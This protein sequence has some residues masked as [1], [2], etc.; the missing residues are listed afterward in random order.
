MKMRNKLLYITIS[1][2][3]LLA[4][5]GASI[6]F[7]N[8]VIKA[9]AATISGGKLFVQIRDIN[10]LKIGDNVI[11]GDGYNFLDCQAGNPIFSRVSP[12]DGGNY[13]ETKLYIPSNT[14]IVPMKVEAGGYENTY[15]FK[16]VKEA[17]LETGLSYP[18][19]DK[20]LSYGSSYTYSSGT[21][22]TLGDINFVSS[23]NDYSSWKVSFDNFGYAHMQFNSEQYSTEIRCNTNSYTRPHIGYYSPDNYYGVKLYREIDLSNLKVERAVD[24]DQTTVLEGSYIDLSGLELRIS[25]LEGSDNRTFISE[26]NTDQPFYDISAAV[27]GHGYVECSFCGFT[28]NVACNVVSQ[29]AAPTYYQEMK[30]VRNDYRGTYILGVEGS[31]LC[32]LGAITG[33]QKDQADGQYT[34]YET[35]KQFNINVSSTLDTSD[36]YD[37]TTIE[38][39]Y[40]TIQRKT[41]DGVSYLFLVSKEGEYLTN[42]NNGKDL[43]YL[44][45][46]LNVNDAI[47]IDDDLYIVRNNKKLVYNDDSELFEFVSS[48]ESNHSRIKLFK[49]I[50]DYESEVASFVSGFDS[51]THS[52]CDEN[53]INPTTID[54]EGWSSQANAFN[55][56]SP[57]AQGYLANVEYIH[58][59]EASGSTAD[60]I[61]RY[62]YIVSKYDNLSDFMNRKDANTI[63]DYTNKV[64]NLNAYPLIEKNVNPIIV[65]V[66]I[67]LI[68]LSTL[69]TFVLFIRKKKQNH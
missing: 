7:N 65:V 10:D 50:C 51:Y 8:N 39:N 14:A 64:E 27:K 30:T 5:I 19:R 23:K 2:F 12:F 36:E 35:I 43:P 31:K 68:T 40:Y 62:D 21:I 61:D 63:H 28:F 44:T 59:G 13:D 58:N 22:Q 26:Y 24:Q 47:S 1:V 3:C 56:L 48:V 34:A 57:D 16:S 55:A 60:I 49:K 37:G 67:S 45:E 4:G 25:Y 42:I 33:T 52:H 15:S 17:S 29:E 32:I 69:I 18:T 6:K 66:F 9:N 38:N 41:I 46:T 54:S 11:I 53:G 20:Y